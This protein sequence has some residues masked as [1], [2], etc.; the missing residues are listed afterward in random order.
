[1]PRCKASEI[2]RN[3][4]YLSVRRSDDPPSLKL[5]RDKRMRIT[6]QMGVFRH[7]PREVGSRHGG[8]V[9]NTPVRDSLT[10]SHP[11][12]IRHRQ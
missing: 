3:E 9:S 10:F 11:V 5:R 8:A 4:A 12:V 6:P 7:P 2:L 1:M